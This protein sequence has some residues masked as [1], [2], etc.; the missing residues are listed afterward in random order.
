MLLRNIETARSS[1]TGFERKKEFGEGAPSP[2]NILLLTYGVVTDQTL[3]HAEGP[4]RLP[5]RMR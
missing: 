1:S 2:D 5:A 4:T 3:D